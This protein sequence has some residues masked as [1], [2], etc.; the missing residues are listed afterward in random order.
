ME[1]SDTIKELNKNFKVT[2]I[3]TLD[4][5]ESF[6]L[7]RMFSGSLLMDELTGGG[8]G[9]K[10]RHLLF[11]YKS[12]GKNALLNQTIAYNQRICRH[13][14]KLLPEFYNN[15]QDRHSFFIKH[16]LGIGECKCELPEGRLFIIA[17]Y[18]KSQSL[19]EASINILRNI[20]VKETGE[21]VDEILYDEKIELLETLSSKQDILEEEKRQI[22]EI[23]KWIKSLNIESTE[24][25]QEASIDYLSKCGI[26]VD[27]LLI[28]D[29]SDTEEGVEIVIPLIRDNAVDGIIWDSLQSSLPRYVKERD[30]ASMTMGVESKSNGLLLRHMCSAFSAKD[31]T[32]ET[33]AY[34][35]AFFL[36][37]QI[38]SSIGGFASKDTYSGGH[39]VAHLMDF[40]S[41]I[42]KEK[43][44]KIDGTESTTFK[45]KF[46]GQKVR[47]RAEKSK[48]SVP[49]EMYEYDYYFKDSDICETGEIDHISE[50]I[51]LGEEKGVITK[52]GYSYNIGTGEKF[53][54]QKALREF[55][56]NNPEFMGQVYKKIKVR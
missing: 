45:D 23:N 19:E 21:L 52:E 35:P 40:V 20:T 13:C 10:R 39:I 7:K 11:G 42:K 18:E 28:C 6:K 51:I 25:E 46:Y 53:K 49:G 14:H 16:V 36:T 41:E 5:A 43:Y 2:K 17:D 33:E 44:L 4:K 56:V 30:A 29:P 37:A 31:L 48:M 24:I 50:L 15:A 3:T 38:R 12:A 32:M 27:K 26:L 9:F 22:K 47:I 54:G 34:K 8:W 55:F 1:L